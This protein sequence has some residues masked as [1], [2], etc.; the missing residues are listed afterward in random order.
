MA[1][2]FGIGCEL[3]TTVTEDGNVVL[4]RKERAHSFVNNFASLILRSLDT[5]SNTDYKDIN[6]AAVMA[7][8]ACSG[9][10]GGWGTFYACAGMNTVA[11]AGEIN[12]GVVVGTS[13]TP[14][15]VS[16]YNLQAPIA[17][18]VSAGQLAYAAMNVVADPTF[19]TPDIL[20][21]A[22]RDIAN[23]SGAS[24]TVR[25]IGLKGYPGATS[26]SLYSVCSE[27]LYLR[28]VVPDTVVNSGQVLNVKYTLKTVVA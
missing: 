8:L 21:E 25:E 17:N 13:N 24:I 4:R 1:L 20:L 14:F 22:S 11:L 27:I 10:G 3:E 12:R 16:Q 19:V 18:G 6:N 23:N 9:N 15:A 26:Y 28:D 2:R 5:A 7:A